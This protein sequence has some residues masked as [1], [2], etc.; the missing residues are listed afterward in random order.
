LRGRGFT[1]IE[2]LVV[3][4]V[5]AV[6]IALLLPA[7]Q[8]A[9]EAARRIQCTNNLKQL[10]LAAASY[11][12]AV[13]CLPQGAAYV[14]R[15]A[16]RPDWVGP[17]VSSSPF[18]ALLPDLE[19]RALFNAVNYDGYMLEPM[20][21]TVCATGLSVLCC[22]SDPTVSQRQT[23]ADYDWGDG[24]WTFAYTSYAGNHGPWTVE[25]RLPDQ[26][27]LGQN[28]G[29]FHSRS[30]IRPA[31]VT[32]GLSQTI[33]FGE[34]AH[35]LLVS[36]ERDWWNWW[37]SC[38]WDTIFTTWYGINPHRKTPAGTVQQYWATLGSLS[39]FHPGGANV[40]MLDGSVHFL[41]DTI[42]SWPIDPATGDA[43]WDWDNSC[44]CIRYLTETRIY[45]D[46]SSRN[47][48]YRPGTRHGVLQAL[49][50]RSF[51]EVISAEDY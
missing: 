20:T 27:L 49:S 29:V 16:V 42:D 25:T 33:V 17:F 41:K 36:E 51:G 38:C 26:R 35:G 14:D 22:P 48:R 5:I 46:T 40:A 21:A 28:P 11:T 7:L 45:W 32:D 8:A 6:L 18:V 34:R 23:L 4:A 15:V 39:S 47:L 44:Q 9:R 24:P 37:P 50:T 13:G 19:Q 31:Q 2:L 3:I 1:L 43:G 12:E 30:A 10:A